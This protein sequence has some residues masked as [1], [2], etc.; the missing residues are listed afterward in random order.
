MHKKVGALIVTA[1]AVLILSAL[2]L[3]LYNEEE[4]IQA[5]AE[6][7]SALALIQASIEGVKETQGTYIP[8]ITPTET[9]S[10]PT[11]IVTETTVVT[12]PTEPQGNIVLRAE[13]QGSA[14]VPTETQSNLPVTTETQS[15]PVAAATAP[16][17]SSTVPA[18]TSTVP[19]TIPTVPTTVPQVSV[20]SDMA[21]I[22][23]V[24][25]STPTEPVINTWQTII[26]PEKPTKT[27]VKPEVLPTDPAIPPS[28]P[29]KVQLTE[30]PE[31]SILDKKDKTDAIQDPVGPFSPEMTRAWING[32]EYIGYLTIYDLE[33]ELPVIADW[34]YE[35]LQIAPCRQ[36]GSTRTDDFVIAAHNYTSH[37]G[38]LKD[39]KPGA[40]LTFT[41]MDGYK[42]EYEMVR[43]QT[44]DA[45]A[46]DAVQFSGCDLVLYTCTPGGAYRVGAFFDRVPTK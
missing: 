44:L 36:F 21:V 5:G 3:F 20:S 42:I 14:T 40:R 33:L 22:G 8:V 35:R 29:V 32:N 23:P 27:T 15:T 12:V 13:T 11:V 18:T 37:F 41:E 45:V 10:D 17:T 16:T 46:I 34:T 19:T 6:A 30:N 24:R 43:L 25:P 39:L 7:E 26:P 2:L 1:G 9:T 31:K 28:E 38:T 4:D